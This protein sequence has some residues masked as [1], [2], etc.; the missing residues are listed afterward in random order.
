MYIFYEIFNFVLEYV[1]MKHEIFSKVLIFRWL[2]I[3]PLLFYT[4]ILFDFIVDYYH[5]FI[6]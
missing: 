6:F 4:F 2:F 5:N 3:Q 1:K